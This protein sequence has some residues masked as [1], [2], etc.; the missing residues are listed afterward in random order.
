MFLRFRC[1]S[2]IVTF[3]TL[4]NGSS[5]VN[6]TTL[7]RDVVDSLDSSGLLGSVFEVDPETIVFQGKK[8]LIW[9]L[10]KTS[11]GFLYFSFVKRKIMLQKH[12]KISLFFKKFWRTL[13]LFVGVLI[14]LLVISALGFKAKLDTLTC[15]LHNLHAIHSS[16]LPLLWHLLASW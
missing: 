9:Q 2:V 10:F 1:S 14:P 13:L 12:H 3:E 11:C 8:Y 16:Y 5:G 6:V 4:F 15:I 7:R